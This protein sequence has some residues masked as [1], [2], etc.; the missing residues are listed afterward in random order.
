MTEKRGSKKIKE[1]IDCLKYSQ[2]N[3]KYLQK[4]EK[5]CHDLMDC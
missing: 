5:N 4:I 3:E 2:K 1:I